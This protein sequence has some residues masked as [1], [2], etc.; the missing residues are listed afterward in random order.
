M[1]RYRV[2]L[3]APESATESTQEHLRRS[4]ATWLAWKKYVEP[5]QALAAADVPGVTRFG[6]HTMTRSALSESA[7]RW[8]LIEKMNT[9]RWTS[10]LT[11]VGVPEVSRAA[12]GISS[13]AEFT[14][15]SSTDDDTSA[16]D[17][18]HAPRFFVPRLATYLL[19]DH[20]WSDGR[21]MLGQVHD[22]DRNRVAALA[23]YL[24]G[25][26]RRLPALV[27]SRP[28]QGDRAGWETAVDAV[29]FAV[30]GYATVWC[31]AHDAT[32]GLQSKL[33]QDL[34]VWGGAVRTY[35]PRVRVGDPTEAGY[36]SRHRVLGWGKL[37]SNPDV[38]ADMLARAARM[39]VLEA[40][41]WTPVP[42]SLNQVPVRLGDVTD[43]LAGIR[44]VA[45]A[46]SVADSATDVSL[47]ADLDDALER[48]ERLREQAVAL[49]EQ[50]EAAMQLAAAAEEEKAA[51]IAE[52]RET[53]QDNIET[54]AELEDAKATI[55]GLQIA[56]AAAQRPM[57]AGGIV[58]PTDPADQYPH[59][60]SFEDLL[61]ILQ[62]IPELTFTGDPRPARALDRHA[63]RR[64]WLAKCWDATLTM[65]EYV[66]AVDAGYDGLFAQWCDTDA[67]P[68]SRTL[69]VG[70]SKALVPG[71]SEQ[72]KGNRGMAAERLLPV[73]ATVD[74]S[75]FKHMWTH[76]RLGGG[77]DSP[78]MHY[79]ESGPQ[80]YIG[81][82]GRHLTNTLT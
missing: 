9:G 6:E 76:I 20:S 36:S 65:I 34:S 5:Q 41:A 27:F 19:K 77:G 49:Q 23:A 10:T 62:D 39:S 40:H 21:L 78:R 4:W 3:A 38:A 17:G 79:H 7:V 29:A 55:R 69:P 47:R 66:R 24:T 16:D 1:L 60:E 53:A 32:D 57:D 43:L 56:V 22:V 13:W 14:I 31:L 8:R 73:P 70:S 25:S 54:V 81:Y 59:P 82:I 18:G 35:L 67:P 61:L 2:L 74:A 48:S 71:E 72:V 46:M 37:R 68:G 15:E 28:P 64:A 58:I 51:A 12:L 26:D 11:Y 52:A 42:L 63:N 75:G 80:I 30:A 50:A 44:P 33:G 45:A